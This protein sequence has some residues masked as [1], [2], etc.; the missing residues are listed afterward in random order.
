MFSDYR[1][2]DAQAQTCS[3]RAF[4]AEK[5]LKELHPM[6][7]SDAAAVITDPDFERP[8]LPHRKGLDANDAFGI[9]ASIDG[10]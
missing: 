5:F 2:C 9:A 7:V 4:G 3:F 6:F 8:L 10:I 1:L